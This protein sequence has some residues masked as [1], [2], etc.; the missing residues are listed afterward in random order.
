MRLRAGN[1]WWGVPALFSSELY[2]GTADLGRSQAARAAKRCFPR[3]GCLCLSPIFSLAICSM[4]IE[5]IDYHL[6]FY[7]GALNQVEHYQMRTPFLAPRRGERVHLHKGSLTMDVTRV[8]HGFVEHE[9]SR[10][11]HIVKVFGD[12]VRSSE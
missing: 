12:E 4:N 8:T 6:E 2:R 11:E 1:R 9:G 10:I 5:S 3:P 7:T